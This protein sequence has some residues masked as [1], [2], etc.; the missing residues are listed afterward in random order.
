MTLQTAPWSDIV[1][2]DVTT[3]EV[4]SPDEGVSA[5]VALQELHNNNGLA[6]TTSQRPQDVI[7][8]DATGGLV[9][10]LRRNTD[11]SA[12]KTLTVQEHVQVQTTLD[13]PSFFVDVYATPDNNASG[14]IL[15][16]MARAIDIGSAA[17]D[18]DFPMPV[19][20]WHLRYN[21][22]DENLT[23][24]PEPILIFQDNGLSV[25]TASAAVLV[26]IDPKENDGKKQ[27]WLFVTGFFT[28]SIAVA[29][30]DL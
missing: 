3:S 26:G 12:P 30:I 23:S 6:H 7:T 20:V 1:H 9:T 4:R 11:P 25:R 18:P 28:R 21:G 27:G 8:T 13:N 22:N 14:L 29:K 15:A 5:L 2:I 19:A 17:K 24:C 16:G 10:R